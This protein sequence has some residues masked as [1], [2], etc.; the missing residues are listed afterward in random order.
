[1]DII[2]NFTGN[3]LNEKK[4]R[5]AFVKR[6]ICDHLILQVI[7]LNLFDFFFGKLELVK[8]RNVHPEVTIFANTCTWKHKLFFDETAWHVIKPFILK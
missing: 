1:M 8:V 7:L 5:Y 4:N 2:Q 3:K 6:L